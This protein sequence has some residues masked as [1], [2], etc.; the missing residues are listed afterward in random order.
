MSL[1]PK[2]LPIYLLRS[3]RYEI[4]I[5]FSNTLLNLEKWGTDDILTANFPT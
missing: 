2:S 4:G 1:T 5:L 3:N